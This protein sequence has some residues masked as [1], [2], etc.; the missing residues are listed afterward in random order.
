MTATAQ[1]HSCAAP[2]RAWRRLHRGERSTYQ[3]DTL[4]LL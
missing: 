4:A 3:I 1:R 2:A